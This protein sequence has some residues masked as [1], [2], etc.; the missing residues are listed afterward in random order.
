MYPSSHVPVTCTV[1][2]AVLVF[3]TESVATQL[4]VVKPIGNTLPEGG[5]QVTVGNGSYRSVAP[6]AK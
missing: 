4:T 3:P 6:R 1:K 2:N 5:V